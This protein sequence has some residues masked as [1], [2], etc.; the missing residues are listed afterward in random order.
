MGDAEGDPVDDRVRALTGT[1]VICVILAAFLVRFVGDG[2]V[3]PWLVF[4]VSVLGLAAGAAVL[5][6]RAIETAAAV[7]HLRDR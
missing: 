4:L 2:E 6:D 1:L 3:A 7:L 5:G